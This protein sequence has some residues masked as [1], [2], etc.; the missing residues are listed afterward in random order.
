MKKAS[1]LVPLAIVL[2]AQP[3]NAT[4]SLCNVLRELETAP[5]GK[6]DDPH[7]RRW[8]EFHWGFDH[9]DGTIWSW[10]CRHSSHSI[11][12]QTCKWLTGHTSRE[13]TMKLP[14][15]IMSCY[16]YRFPRHAEYD[17]TAIAG[18]I[19][20]HG[21]RG[22]RLLLDLSY[23]DLPQGEVA[24]RLAVEADDIKYDP[25]ELPPIG[26]MPVDKPR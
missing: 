24:M 15:Q 25:D 20:L 26:P 3:A 19:T 11:A 16:G 1:I 9:S 14:Q 23:R 7:R 8:V 21:H 22:N 13:F 4:S 10:G 17:W 6:A 2:G 5:S 18:T 12:A